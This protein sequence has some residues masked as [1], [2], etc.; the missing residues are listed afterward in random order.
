MYHLKYC[1]TMTED[2]GKELEKTLNGS[3][4]PGSVLFVKCDVTK[5]EDI[6]VRSKF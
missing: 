3:G 2:I 5:E 6:E 1:L 4:R